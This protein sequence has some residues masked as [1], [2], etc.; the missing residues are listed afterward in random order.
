MIHLCW[1]CDRKT[2]PIATQEL[3][4]VPAR[5]LFQLNISV[6]SDEWG[7]RKCPAS[8]SVSV[9]DQ[10]PQTI[11]RHSRLSKLRS[12]QLEKL[13]NLIWTR[14]HSS[15]LPI[16]LLLIDFS[17]CFY[18]S[19]LYWISRRESRKKSSIK[20]RKLIDW[21]IGKQ[22]KKQK[23]KRKAQTSR[24]NCK[25]RKRKKR[26][27]VKV[28]NCATTHNKKRAKATKQQT[29]SVFQPPSKRASSSAEETTRIF[30][31]ENLARAPV[32]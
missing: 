18:V 28:V 19:I 27:E 9:R 25:R 3:I 26:V 20:K 12:R 1:V 32:N 8:T 5:A 6:F 23:Q 22:K 15:S 7:S 31:F 30:S 10:N 24:V 16:S 4:R 2:S 21:V 29:E 13:S 17:L 11:D 14:N